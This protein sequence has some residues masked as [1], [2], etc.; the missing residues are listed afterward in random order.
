MIGICAWPSGDFPCPM[1]FDERGC[2]DGISALL[3]KCK[4]VCAW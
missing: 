4:F 3:G 2:M 1:E